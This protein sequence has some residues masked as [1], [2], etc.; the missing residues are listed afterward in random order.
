MDRT[1]EKRLSDRR[2]S[3]WISLWI[4]FSGK[5]R[6]S[7]TK[8]LKALIYKGF[9]RIPEMPSYPQGLWITLWITSF[10]RVSEM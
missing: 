4:T 8:T 5:G 9:S 1:G 7:G 3:L 2:L 6:F 10:N